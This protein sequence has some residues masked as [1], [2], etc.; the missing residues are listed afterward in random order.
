[1]ENTKGQSQPGS[2]SA[3]NRGENRVYQ[4]HNKTDISEQ[5]K[6]DIAAEIGE[7]SNK[8]ADLKD[9]GALSGRDDAAGGSG[10]RMEEQSTGQA[11]DR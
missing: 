10:D 11:T 8:V 5:E 2:G 1:M 7:D 9:T 6:K 3:E 4:G